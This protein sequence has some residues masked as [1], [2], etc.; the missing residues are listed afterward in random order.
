MYLKKKE[1]KRVIANST[2]WTIWFSRSLGKSFTWNNMWNL[3]Q[4]W[5]NHVHHNKSV[6]QL[7]I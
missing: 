3:K 5:I 6:N 4:L 7:Y 2:H 1:G